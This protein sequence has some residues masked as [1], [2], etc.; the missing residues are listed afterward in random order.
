MLLKRHA[1]AEFLIKSVENLLKSF[2]PIR[3]LWSGDRWSQF[4]GGGDIQ[5]KGKVQTLWLAGRLPPILLLSWAFWSP[6]KKNSE[7]GTWSAYCSDFEKSKWEYFLSNKYIYS[8]IK[9]KIKKRWQILW[10]GIQS[11]KN[12]QSISGKKHYWNVNGNPQ[13]YLVSY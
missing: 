13:E 7:E 2:L 6:H 5:Q 4:F 10:Y 1:L 3:D 11:T 8:K 9:I 12:Y